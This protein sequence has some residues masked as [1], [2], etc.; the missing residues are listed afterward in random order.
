MTA[1]DIAD[2]QIREFHYHIR[3][4]SRHTLPGHH[5]SSRAGA[6]NEYAA[7]APLLDYPDA[8]R[9]DVRRS[10]RDPFGQ[11]FVRVYNQPS[12]T[13]VYALVDLSGSMG[14]QGTVSKLA[15]MMDFVFVLAFSAG[16][17][18]DPFGLVAGADKVLSEFLLP[19]TRNGEVVRET[20]RRMSRFRPAARDAQGLI[21]AAPLLGYRRSLVFIVS[22]FHFPAAITRRMLCAF[23][24]HDIV[25]IVIWDSAEFRRPPTYGLARVR[26]SETGA[27]RYLL[28]RRAIR[29]RLVKT[30]AARREA[31]DRLFLEFEHKPYFLIDKLD[32][33]DI[34]RFFM[35]R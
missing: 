4:R 24:R 33:D 19:A 3:W 27:E 30:F 23:A 5:S 8:R 10:V 16:R 35:E 20:L 2:A 17:T 25:P 13:P 29:N 7:S 15:L 28:L 31:L 9:L 6:G 11:L 1:S 14:F 22:D 32:C 26:D 34:N 12:S 18:G 21:D